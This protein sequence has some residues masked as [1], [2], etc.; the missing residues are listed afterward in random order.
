MRFT[1]SSI[2]ASRPAILANVRGDARL[3]HPGDDVLPKV[4]TKSVDFGHQ[5][6]PR[7]FGQVISSESL[8]LLWKNIAVIP[9]I[10]FSGNSWAGSHQYNPASTQYSPE[11][12]VTGATENP[13]T[14]EELVPC[15]HN[16]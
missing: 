14:T 16:H 7:N 5:R 12:H 8:L 9:P 6:G 15:R 10:D 3:A 13:A 11:C 2:L 4:I 1:P